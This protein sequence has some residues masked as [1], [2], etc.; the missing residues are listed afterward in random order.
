VGLRV[1]SY[2]LGEL[3][4]IAVPGAVAPSLFWTLPVGPWEPRELNQLWHWFTRDQN[5]CHDYGLLLVKDLAARERTQ[6]NVDLASLGAS[7]SELMPAGVQRFVSPSAWQH[8]SSRLL[9]LSGAYPQ[10]G[11]GVLLKWPDDVRSFDKLVT[12]TLSQLPGGAVTQLSVFKVATE[13]YRHRFGSR[14]SPSN[15]NDSTQTDTR[16]AFHRAVEEAAQVQW[17]TGP[18]FLLAFEEHCRQQGLWVR[19]LPWDPARMVGWKLNALDVRLDYRDLQAVARELAPGLDGPDEATTAAAGLADGSYFTDYVHYVAMSGEGVSP[20]SVT[21]QL[22]GRL[23]RPTEMEGLLL[24]LGGRVPSRPGTAQLAEELLGLLGWR[25]SSE[26]PERPLASCFTTIDGAPQLVG[27]LSGNDLRI[28]VESFCKD[29]LD[30]VVAKL[31]YDEDTLWRAI[32]E[33]APEYRASSHSMAWEEEVN[34]LTPGSAAVLLTALGP[35][36]FPTKAD[37]VAELATV[38]QTLSGLLNAVSHH[39]GRE[40]FTPEALGQTPALIR[41]LIVNAEAL[42]EDLPWHLKVNFVYGDQPKILSGEA[43]SHGSATPRLLRVLDWTGIGERS[44]VTIWNK[45]RRN[46]VVTDPVFIT[47][48]SRRSFVE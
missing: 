32:Q 14:S 45:T 48:P 38:L 28:I 12:H 47:R 26:V 35:L 29:V 30:V 25:K 20:R 16:K 42:L 46:P 9:V 17:E 7:L 40:R 22:L 44:Y 36:G 23:L 18:Q 10:P 6:S 37:M 15:P 11:W 19:S 39:G 24:R 21:L 33:R 2:S 34:R 31:G 8:E 41:Q 4:R 1:E 13:A 27:T 3:H 5:V 43:W